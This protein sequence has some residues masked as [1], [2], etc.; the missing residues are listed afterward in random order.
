MCFEVP[1]DYEIT[2]DGKKLIGSAQTRR[3]GGD[4]VLQHGALPLYGDVAR[5]CE[6]LAFDAEAARSEAQVRVRT[7]AA[8]LEEALGRRAG[9]QEVA[10]A[11]LAGFGEAL[12][13]RFEP[14]RL[15]AAE[16]AEAG[17]LRAEKYASEAWTSKH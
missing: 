6:A 4:V 15:S 16:Q 8:T 9:F 13:L 5:I 17:R 1:S 12:N 11:M 7:R 2:V 10:Q 14:G 3:G